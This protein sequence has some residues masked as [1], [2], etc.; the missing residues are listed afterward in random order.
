MALIAV[1]IFVLVLAS[2]IGLAAENKDK[3]VK[4]FFGE[5]TSYQGIITL[6]NIDTFEG[7]TVGKSY[8]L[9]SVASRFEAQNKGALIK[10]ENLLK[11]H[12]NMQSSF[13]ENTAQ[14][15]YLSKLCLA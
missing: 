14:S 8:F 13:A 12:Q 6:W 11:S 2:T 10:V 5:K 1:L 9:E 7:G 15:Q 4:K 3:L